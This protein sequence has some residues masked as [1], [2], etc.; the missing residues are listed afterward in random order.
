MVGADPDRAALIREQLGLDLRC[1]FVKTNGAMLH[2]LTR[3]L[4]VWVF[5]LIDF[6][7]VQINGFLR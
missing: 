5:A 4:G 6:L 1:L 7:G 2:C 3:L